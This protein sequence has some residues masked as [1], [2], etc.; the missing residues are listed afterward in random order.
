MKKTILFALIAVGSVS[1]FAGHL[2]SQERRDPI[3]EKQYRQDQKARRGRGAK[4]DTP[5]ERRRRGAEE[6]TIRLQKE[7][8]Q[9]IR[10]R[11]QTMYDEEIVAM[12]AVE[13]RR[14]GE[15][16]SNAKLRQA[17]K[18]LQEI[19]KTYPKSEAAKEA[20]KM[21]GTQEMLE[22]KYNVR[23]KVTYAGKPVQ[24]EGK[25]RQMATVTFSTERTSDDCPLYTTGDFKIKL[26]AGTYKVSVTPHAIDNIPLVLRKR[27]PKHFYQLLTTDLVVTVKP[28]DNVFSFDVSTHNLQPL[29]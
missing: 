5:K 24:F 21:L 22:A 16:D 2:V 17:E 15:R 4:G 7:Y 23:G 19:L 13:R 12:I 10:Q 14:L 28:G 9:L 8:L 26:P 18:L 3:T 6:T 27:D 1:F 11:I 29:P 20:R 25:P